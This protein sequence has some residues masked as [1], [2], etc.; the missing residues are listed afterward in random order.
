MRRDQRR[1]LE[2]RPGNRP[3]RR[4][5][6][7][8]EGAKTEPAY[9]NQLKRDLRAAGVDLEVL[10][11][12]C[13]S[14]PIS[15]VDAALERRRQAAKDKVPYDAVW[16]VFDRDGHQSFARAV[17]KAEANKLE[18]AISV[19]CFEFWLLLHFTYTAKA[20]QKGDDVVREL[21]KHLSDYEKS[22]AHGETWTARREQA[23]AN[24]ER[25]AI[26]QKAVAD[27]PWANPSTTVHELVKALKALRP[28]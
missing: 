11:E 13:G 1:A 4:V 21:R 12:E 20:F 5:L 8:C 28:Y 23:V 3:G 16:C 25:L 6:I 24:A 10:G 14:A 27:E 18:L 9:F 19:R 2:R 22:S 17:D 15:V 26:H 7:A